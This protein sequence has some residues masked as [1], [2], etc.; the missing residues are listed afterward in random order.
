MGKGIG[1][2]IGRVSSRKLHRIFSKPAD[3]FRRD[4]RLLNHSKTFYS[5]LPRGVDS[6]S[7]EI[8]DE[9]SFTTDE[10]IAWAVLNI[11]ER[12]I[13]GE[14]VDDWYPLS[15]KQ[16]DLAEGQG[17]GSSFFDEITGTQSVAPVG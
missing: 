15:G 2:Q 7:V 10:R 17:Q 14:T 11:P 12:V 6:F 16:G 4:Y 9:K 1:F 8:F 5:T 3:R 13:Q